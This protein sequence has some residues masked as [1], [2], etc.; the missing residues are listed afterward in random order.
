MH[1]LHSIIS[2]IFMFC[3]IA[4]IVGLIKPG[5]VLFWSN[6]KNRTRVLLY[7]GVTMILFGTLTSWVA[8]YDPEYIAEK[9]AKEATKIAEKLTAE[10]VKTE[11]VAEQQKRAE[12][13]TEEMKIGAKKLVIQAHEITVNKKL[14]TGDFKKFDKNFNNMNKEEKD[15]TIGTYVRWMGKVSNVNI[16]DNRIGLFCLNQDKEM[17]NVALAVVPEQADILKKIKEDDIIDFVAKINLPK[18]S[19]TTTPYYLKEGVIMQ[20]GDVSLEK[21]ALPN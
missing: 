15:K 19:G 17:Q 4:L 18:T 2:N 14:Y 21:E 13:Q 6:I 8:N 10:A 1:T 5:L 3:F 12:Q 11:K 7:F 9:E 16:K 20:Y